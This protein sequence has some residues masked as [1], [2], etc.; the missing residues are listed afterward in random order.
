MSVTIAWWGDHNLE[1]K[2]LADDPLVVPQGDRALATTNSICSRLPAPEK[3]L[4]C[5]QRAFLN[6]LNKAPEVHN[7]NRGLGGLIMCTSIENRIRAFV[8]HNTAGRGSWQLTS[9]SGVQSWPQ[10]F[11]DT[12]LLVRALQAMNPCEDLAALTQAQTSDEFAN[13]CRRWIEATENLQTAQGGPVTVGLPAYRLV[14]RSDGTMDGPRA[15]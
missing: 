5:F 8:Y 14:L 10:V 3:A 13:R 4:P 7:G 11:G 15:L 1:P 9:D 12:S 2:V 6:E